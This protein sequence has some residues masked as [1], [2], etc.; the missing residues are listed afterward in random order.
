VSIRIQCVHLLCDV[1]CCSVLWRVA[2][3]VT[4]A[5]HLI[6]QAC[7]NVLQCAVACC[8]VWHCMQCDTVRFGFNAATQV[9]ND[10]QCIAVFCK[11]CSATEQGLVSIP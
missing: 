3:Q 10:S 7:C 8:S 6:T 9:V 2:L 11:V 1:V 5:G 4:D